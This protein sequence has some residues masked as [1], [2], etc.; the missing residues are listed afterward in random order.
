MGIHQ[1]YRRLGR[2]QDFHPKDLNVHLALEQVLLISFFEIKALNENDICMYLV[3]FSVVFCY[4]DMQ[5]SSIVNHSLLHGDVM[6]G[7]FLL[8]LYPCFTSSVLRL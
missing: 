7:I 2:T 4:T 3:Y 1:G 6:L 8:S 5:F